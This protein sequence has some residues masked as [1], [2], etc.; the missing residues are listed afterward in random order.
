MITL[1]LWAF[2]IICVFAGFSILAILYLI[3][4]F[5][6]YCIDENRNHKID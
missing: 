4:D 6:L 1:P 5:I 3:I 2:I